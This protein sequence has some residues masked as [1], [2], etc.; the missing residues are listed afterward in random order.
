[1]SRLPATVPYLAVLGVAAG[2]L[3]GSGC[4]SRPDWI[5]A[6]LVTVDVT[7]V[8][9]GPGASQAGTGLVRSFK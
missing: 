1:M 5:E 6:T 7:G 2:L 3:L 8:W 9:Y 4:V